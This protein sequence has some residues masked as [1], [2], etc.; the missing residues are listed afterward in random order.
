MAE[1]WFDLLDQL[2][3]AKGKKEINKL[4]NDMNGMT[5][6][7]SLVKGGNDMNNT[8]LYLGTLVRCSSSEIVFHSMV[9]N[10]SHNLALLPE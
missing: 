10:A 7:G 5:I 4:R 9:K 6:I 8:Q 1:A 2:E 3:A